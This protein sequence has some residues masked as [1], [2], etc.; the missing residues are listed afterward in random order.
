MGELVLDLHARAQQI[1]DQVNR[2]LATMSSLSVSD[3]GCTVSVFK[4]LATAVRADR[5]V[6]EAA[7]QMPDGTVCSSYGCPLVMAVLPRRGAISYCPRG[8]RRR[9]ALGA[10]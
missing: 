10:R 5:Y 7:P 3:K 6:Y 8:N 9:I 2:V 1:D 4:A